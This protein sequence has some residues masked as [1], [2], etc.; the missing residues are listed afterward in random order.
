MRLW[1]LSLVVLVLSVLPQRAWGQENWTDRTAGAGIGGLL[2]DVAYGGGVFV[3][4]GT[5]TALGTVYSSPD[6]VTWTNRTD[7]LNAGGELRGVHFAD[8]RFV[9][10][11]TNSAAG[12]LASSTD[13][14]NWA[15]HTAAAGVGGVL[16]DVAYGNGVWVAVGHTGGSLAAIA[17]STDGSVWTNRSTTAGVGG[18][19][20]GV[21]FANGQFVAV[22]TNGALV[23]LATSTNGQTWNI[24]TS[25]NSIQGAAYAVTHDGGQFIATGDAGAAAG[26]T[27]A[28]VL[29]S[30]NG[31][32]WTSRSLAA[33][34][35]GIGNGIGH[36]GGTTVLVGRTGAPGL[37]ATSLDAL[38]WTNR[39]TAVGAPGDL[40]GVAASPTLWV[41][42]GTNNVN[43]VVLTSPRGASGGGG[44]EPVFVDDAVSVPSGGGSFSAAVA[45]GPGVSW[46][47]T[48]SADWIFLG[49]TSGTGNGTVTGSVVGNFL[50]TPRSTTIN[51]GTDTLLVTQAGS[52]LNAPV[53]SGFFSASADAITL[54]WTYGGTGDG[55][56][57]E[58]SLGPEFPWVTWGT[59]D[60]IGTRT[61]QDLSAMGGT[62]YDY[63]V[64]AVAGSL[65]SPWSN[66]LTVAQPP[67][68]P[69]DLAA[70]ARSASQ[71]ELTWSDVDGEQGYRLYRADGDETF[72]DL[73]AILPANEVRYV[74]SGL[75]PLTLYRYQIEAESD[76]FGRLSGA[77][78]V[79][80]PEETRTVRWRAVEAA[81]S[82]YHGVAAGHG[83]IVAVGT[84]GR[85][86]TSTNG[87]TWLDL[88]PRPTAATLRAIAFDGSRFVAVGEGGAILHSE[89]GTSWT[90]A[91]NPLA[92]D[93]SGVA[94]FG[95]T[96]YAAGVAGALLTSPDGATWTEAPSPAEGGFV[97]IFAGDRLVAIEAT[98]RLVS[99]LD[100]S[101][102]ELSRADAPPDETERFFWTRTAGAFGGGNYTL[103]GPNSYLSHSPDALAWTEGTDGGFNYWEAI[104]YGN[105]RFVAVGINGRTGFSANG[106][107]FLGGASQE[108]TLH[109]VAHTPHGFIAVG[110]RG[111]IVTSPDGQNWQVRQEAEGTTANLSAIGA[112][113]S[114]LV[115]FGESSLDGRAVSLHNALD[116]NGWVESPLAV[117]GLDFQPRPNA[118]IF[119]NGQFVAAGDEGLILTS[120]DGR[121]WTTRRTRSPGAFN[122]N[123]RSLATDGAVLLAGGGSVGLLRSSNGGLNWEAVPALPDPFTPWNLAHGP[124][125][126][127]QF[128][129]SGTLRL[130]FSDDGSEWENGF[131][132]GQAGYVGTLTRGMLSGEP[133]FVGVGADF[134]GETPQ[135]MVSSDGRNWHARPA[136]GID[137]RVQAVTFGAG[138]F[139]AVGRTGSY[140]WA[141][142]NG[143]D[144]EPIPPEN[145]PPA[146]ADLGGFDDVVFHDGVF[147][148]V[149]SSGLIA[150]L[151]A[152]ASGIPLAGEIGEVGVSV[153]GAVATLSWASEVG[154]AYQLVTRPDLATGS[155]TTVGPPLS[156]TGGVLS[157]Q[158]D[159][160]APGALP[161]FWAVVT[162]A[163]E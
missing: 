13:G 55:Y 132:V 147:H 105:Q 15:N 137:S 158:V 163:D 21:A 89:N 78:G 70:T 47:A 59:V 141:S 127:G 162:L 99:S 65:T 128:G 63:R 5:N 79:T 17:T 75:D 159:L 43:G 33:G 126:V 74:D 151:G 81:V 34:L 142:L 106:H 31:Q 83:V 148:A 42:V 72:F 61:A 3:A 28:H 140:V 14:A 155:W 87:T 8:G 144:W 153:S 135:A 62:R 154:S 23:V 121:A 69:D 131:V 92:Q 57:I 112:G 30:S 108:D 2:Y 45:A 77:V 16:H 25:A 80:T 139:L 53:L 102:W 101:V 39:T 58:R 113:P 133:I 116:G 10:V 44:S 50:P 60:S 98:G 104:A 67:D 120:P 157:T 119:V 93:L 138:L 41:A 160:T 129:G 136:T 66:T 95:G 36:A 27:I 143:V 22:G 111:L 11:G 156:G 46:T 26:S 35:G 94:P 7:S 149:G 134:S 90:A 82:N 20:H 37:L 6:G 114:S 54:S 40:H 125:W 88:A 130:W 91:S 103:V 24:R 76:V 68:V 117:G 71:I 51:L 107:S 4:V 1:G 12:I 85:I 38:N 118:V 32:A 56:E 96:W 150:T 19:L 110:A 49:N 86:T 109:G 146:V 52:A 18:I 64:R 145:L 100:G 122:D 48:E 115:V 84:A 124:R 9:A 29:T 161:G 73:V 152:R 123:L 97:G